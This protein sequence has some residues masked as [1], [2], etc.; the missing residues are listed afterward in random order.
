[1]AGLL[2]RM[3]GR[4]P[5]E[6]RR[7]SSFYYPAS[8]SF[9]GVPGISARQAETIAAIASCLTL[10]SN[11]L[12]TLPATLTIATPDGGRAPAPRT[13]SAWALLDRPNAFMAWPTLARWITWEALSFGNA[14]C[15]LGVDGRGAINELR[16]ISWPS[17]LPQVIVGG[18]G[19]RRLVYDVTAATAE[20]AGLPRRLLDTDVVHVRTGHTGD[21]IIG[22]SVFRSA[23]PANEAQELEVLTSSLWR[24]SMRPSAILT[25]PTF[26][27][28]TQ[29]ERFDDSWMDRLVGSINAGR[30]PIVEGGFK[31]EQVSGTAQDAQLIESRMHNVSDVC[32]LFHIPENLVQP[33]T[34]AISDPTPYLQLF[35]SQALAP[36]VVEIEH[37]FSHSAL[38]ADLYLQLD[39]TGLQRGSFSQ[40]AAAM[41]GT[42]GAGITTSNEAR[43]SMGYPARPDGNDLRVNGTLPADRLGQPSMSDKPGPTGNT[44]PLPSHGN[45][46]AK[47]NGAAVL[48]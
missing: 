38:P 41:I 42:T 48:Q 12:G 26:L 43:V 44:V 21:G 31:L 47:P 46:G 5:V 13:A 20:T 8:L 9:A 28:P 27:Q 17:L 2:S 11:A 40:L 36:L 39:M 32:R 6:E 18:D 1:M 7:Q 24:N 29:R 37:Q 4:K 22:Q 14:V 30:V 35:A 15:W 45:Q 23:G 16:P 25:S 33:G 10:I 3:F 34:R 19:R